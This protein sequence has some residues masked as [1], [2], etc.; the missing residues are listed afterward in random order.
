[1][2]ASTS[3]ATAAT[4]AAVSSV[5]NQCFALAPSIRQGLAAAATVAIAA[6]LAPAPAM[7]DETCLSPYM[8]KI[9]GHEDYV[10]VWTLGVE[11]LG[12]GSDKLVTIDVRDTEAA[13]QSDEVLCLRPGTDAALALAMT[14]NGA[15]GQ[16][17]DEM[18]IALGVDGVPRETLNDTN[19]T[20]L[21]ALWQTGDP[22]AELAVAN[23]VWY[24]ERR[25]VLDSFRALVRDYYDAEVEPITTADAINAWVKEKTRGRIE[26]IIEGEV[27]TNVVAYLI[28]ALYFK[29]DWTYQFDEA[30]TRE[31]PFHRPDGSAV[32]VPMMSQEGDFEM[33]SDADMRMLRLPYGAGRF[34]MI[35]G[36][37]Q[38]GSDL[39]IIAERL[40]SERWRAWMAEFEEVSGVQVRLPRFEVEWESSLVESLVA[41][42]MVIP[43]EPGLADF[44]DMFDGGGP[45]I[46]KVLQ[47]TFL[48]VDEQGS[49][50]AA[51]TKVVMVDSAGPEIAF[52]RPFFLAIYDHATETVLFLGQITDPTA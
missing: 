7:A 42:G 37:P 48:R 36:L 8:P 46:E 10:Y 51:V 47:K 1:M 23:S 11:G 34:S 5:S 35:L 33:R 4:V 52:D 50:A 44:S 14:Y 17:A 3:T 49:E 18:A 15:V 45:W 31:A 19:L 27:P 26:E 16:T 20:W 21:E 41:M 25:P 43:F 30:K 6:A 38:H 32:Q 9:T 24:R 12:D 39:G 2:N 28:N 22:Q 40:E 13:A 29:A